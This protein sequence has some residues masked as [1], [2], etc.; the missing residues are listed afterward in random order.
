MA[1][2]LLSQEVP[3]A[4]AEG[5]H[6][7]IRVLL[8]AR[9]YTTPEEQEHFLAPDYDRDVY[10]PFL[11]SQMER[12]VER[13]KKAREQK[14]KVGIFGDFDADGITSSVLLRDGLEALGMDYV[15][16]IPD[17]LREG[18]GLSSA[19]V[20]F[21]SQAQTTLVFTL[22]CGMM[23]HTEISSLKEHGIETIIIDHHHVPEVLPEAY[24]IINP[25]LPNEGYPF[26]E[27]CGAGTTFKVVQALYTRL[28]PERLEQLKWVLDVVATG[29]VADVMPLIGEN[30]ALVKYGLLVL[31]KTRR[32]GF[33]ALIR[34]GRLKID[35]WNA[36][37]AQTISFQIAPRLNAA[38][39]M[40]HA[41]LA[42][43]LL[44]AQ[45]L[46][47]AEKLAVELENLNLARP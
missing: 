30:R 35:E 2:K 12:V 27:L 15:V 7:V 19:G 8:E 26:R 38:S 10:D 42:H 40:A 9:G 37:K 16:Y 20:D 1:W 29:T 33:Q 43:Q 14:E 11:F 34:T 6:P 17:K 46:E 44:V 23:N 47:S 39:R 24:A 41:M 13:V 25:K 22:D 28:L 4:L 21:F 3:E 45:D 5:L 18:H 31:G 36:A 32:L